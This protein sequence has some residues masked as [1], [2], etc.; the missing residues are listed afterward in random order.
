MAKNQLF[1]VQRYVHKNMVMQSPF[2]GIFCYNLGRSLL[3]IIPLR[4]A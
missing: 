3:E 1:T 4:M 2:V